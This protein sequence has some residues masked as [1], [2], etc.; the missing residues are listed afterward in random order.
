MNIYELL[1]NVPFNMCQEQGGKNCE[2]HKIDKNSFSF[3]QK[4]Q[5]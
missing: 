3:W 5:N 1:Y 2:I 4:R